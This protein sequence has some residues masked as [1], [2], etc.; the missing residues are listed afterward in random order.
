MN[1]AVAVADHVSVVMGA[2]V[3]LADSIGVNSQITDVSVHW[4]RVFDEGLG[5]ADCTPFSCNQSL[6]FTESLSLGD[7]SVSPPSM[8]DSLA[9]SDGITRSFARTRVVSDSLFVSPAASFMAKPTPWTAPGSPLPPI[10]V[11]VVANKTDV[12]APTSISVSGVYNYTGNVNDLVRQLKPAPHFINATVSRSDLPAMAMV[13][14]TYSV[15]ITPNSEI[16]GSDIKMS[17]MVAEIPAHTPVVVPISNTDS[18]AP[19]QHGFPWMKLDY[20]PAVNTTNFALITSVVDAPPHIA[21]QPKADLQP[22]Y[23]DVRWVGDF[24]GTDEPHVQTY[25]AN[26]PTFTFAVTEDWATQKDVKRD[27]RGVPIVSLSLLDPASGKWTD[28]NDIDRPGAAANGQY[29]Y[30]AHLK[31]FSTYA[32]TANKATTTTS[33]PPPVV[34]SG[35]SSNRPPSPVVK[36]Q[37]FTANLEDSLILATSSSSKAISV[38]EEFANEKFSA[39]LLDSV[40]ITSKPVAY[41][42]FRILKGVEVSVTVV[43]VKQKDLAPPSATAVLQTDITNAGD[44]AEKF[45]L[46]FWYNDQTGKRAFD[47]SQQVEVEAHGSKTLPVTIPFTEPGTYHVTAEARSV[48]DN[49]LLES[50]QM[51]VAV[52]WLSVYLYVLIAVAIA[53]LGGSAIAIALYMA[54]NGMMTAAGVGAAG[55]VVATAAGEGLGVAGAGEG[56]GVAGA[57]VAVAAAAGVDVG[58]FAP[59]P[60]ASAP[61]A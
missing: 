31:H 36:P 46:N 12:G 39:R 25:Y 29:V 26:P 44:Q 58:I 27:E 33:T 35:V 34:T 43:D 3:S 32:I 50:T 40:V 6:H 24:P 60:S 17:V 52:P 23:L 21:E 28:I 4:N 41:N 20:T 18:G 59:P 30:M 61:A 42:T 51:T 54:R 56:A 47:L 5:L 10:S 57:G 49:E 55:A 16:H 53:I 37:A 15:P 11:L 8:A 14:P 2:L 9:V 13:L 19:G 22:L 48:P 38:I 45:T 1:D 7:A